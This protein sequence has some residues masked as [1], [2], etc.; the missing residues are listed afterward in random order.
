[1]SDIKPK[2]N[3]YVA[4][5]E[6]L[7]QFVRAEVA[8]EEIKKKGEALARQVGA[9]APIYL[10]SIKGFYFAKDEPPDGW[11]KAGEAPY[12]NA[13]GDLVG[14]PYFAP[15]TNNNQRRLLAVEMRKLNISIFFHLPKTY[16]Q[17]SVVMGKVHNGHAMN[18]MM[19]VWR[20]GEHVLFRVPVPLKRSLDGHDPDKAFIPPDCTPIT[21]Q[22][23]YE[24][25]SVKVASA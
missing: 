10:P 17:N 4:H 1:M 15:R 21:Y 9:E 2:Y 14:R 16:M 8:I 3:Y 11:N 24:L 13:D 12:K 20:H 7:R 18:V 19:E 5:G 25:T 6:T 22:Q 23:Y